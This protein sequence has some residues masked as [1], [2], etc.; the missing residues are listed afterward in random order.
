[1]ILKPEKFDGEN[2]T[3]TNAVE[4]TEPGD[5]SIWLQSFM[6]AEITKKVNAFE[7]V[8][9][10]IPGGLRRGKLAWSLPFKWLVGRWEVK[11]PRMGAGL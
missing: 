6:T 8:I 10:P 2:D 3:F 1:M 11:N 7:M 4:Q 5:I 9:L